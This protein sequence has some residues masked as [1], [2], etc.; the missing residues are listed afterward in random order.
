M[1]KSITTMEGQV[2]KMNDDKDF[3]REAFD[4]LKRELSSRKKLKEDMLTGTI[5][6]FKAYLRL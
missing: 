6:R 4:Q 2:G 3:D 5:P 1:D